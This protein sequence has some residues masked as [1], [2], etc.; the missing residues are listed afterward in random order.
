[1]LK[2]NVKAM[3]YMKLCFNTGAL[4]DIP[5]GSYVL[6]DKGQAVLNGGLA[7]IEAVTGGGNTFKSNTASSRQVLVMD[8]LNQ[9]ISNKKGFTERVYMNIYDADGNGQPAAFH[10]FTD[11]LPTFN[12]EDPIATG[13]VTFTDKSLELGDVFIKNMSTYHDEKIKNKKTITVTT[14]MLDEHGKP[15]EVLLP[16]LWSVDSITYFETTG[17][18]KLADVDIGHKDRNTLN[19]KYGLDKSAFWSELPTECIRANSYCYVTSHIGKNNEIQSGPPGMPPAKAM[20]G[21]S[22]NDKIVGSSRRIYE[23]PHNLWWNK[24]AKLATNQS[25]KGAEYPEY[26]ELNHEPN[27]DQL[28]VDVK[29]LRGKFGP[30]NYT[31]T[32]V[33]SQATGINHE[34]TYL[35]LIRDND[36]YGTSGGTTNFELDLLPGLK[37]NRVNALSK[38]R[39]NPELARAL[40]I[41]AD[42]FQLKQHNRHRELLMTPKDLYEAIKAKGYSWDKLYNTRDWWTIF[43]DLHPIPFLS[44]LDLLRM[45]KSSDPYKP[46]WY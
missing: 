32:L 24:Q 12:H 44:T 42:L 8:H 38:A 18:R 22:P 15:M 34:A 1:M 20:T 10:R 2:P 43:D 5:T 6:G 4:Y 25:T 40:K 39:E 7:P 29:L 14:P 3:P 35:N 21:M 26:P 9:G 33:I 16:N 17:S 46:Y 45:V 13:L 27:N 28:Y 41:T 36:Y 23:V 11:N 31:N 19:L 37:I 30:S